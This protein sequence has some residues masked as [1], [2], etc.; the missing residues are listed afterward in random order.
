MNMYCGTEVYQCN[1]NLGTYE[2]MM[3][4]RS[5]GQGLAFYTTVSIFFPKADQKNYTAPN[6][7]SR[8]PGNPKLK[9]LPTKFEPFMGRPRASQCSSQYFLAKD[10]MHVE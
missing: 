7:C 10:E 5:R 2:W 3:I 4:G 1:Y 6:Q 8:S 9:S